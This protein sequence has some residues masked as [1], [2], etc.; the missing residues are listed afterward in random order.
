MTMLQTPP[1][2][3]SP[4]P[5]PARSQ[6]RSFYITGGTLPPDASSYV[7]RDADAELYDSLRNGE[8]CY[9]L[10]TRQM[11]KSSL[12]IRTAARLRAAGLMVAALDLTAIGQNVSPDQWYD[13]LLIS[14]AE[15]VNLED[16]MEEFW[17]ENQRL[18][19]MQ[20]FLAALRQI[21]LPRQKNGIVLFVDEIDAV[22]SLPFSV[23]E[24][25]GGIRECYN[26]RAQDESFEKLT[27]CLLGVATPADLIDD[28]RISPFN[29]GRR[30]PLTDFTPR[31]AAPLAQGMGPKGPALLARVLYWTNGH[32][33]MTQRLC[34]SVSEQAATGNGVTEADVDR[35]CNDLFLSKAARDTDDNLSFVRTRLL[36]SDAD[37]ASLLDL[38]EKVRTGK[39]VP[40]DETNPLC[41]VLRLSGVARI[42]ERGLLQVRNR[43]YDRV[44]DKEWVIAHMPDAEIRRQ[45]AAYWRGMARA[46]GVGTLITTTMAGLAV[47]AFLQA[48]EARVARDEAGKNLQVANAEKNRAQEQQTRAQEQ[49]A[50]AQEQKLLAQKQTAL[51][52]KA[53]ED[54][55]KQKGRAEGETVRANE[56]NKNL[57]A[58]LAQVKTERE[59]ADSARDEARNQRDAALKARRIATEQ[60]EEAVKQR[61]VAVTR[62]EESRRSQIRLAV[63]N[64][65]RLAS[66][67]D[68]SG[69]TLYLSEARR[70]EA[71]DPARDRLHSIRLSEMMQRNPRLA[72]LWSLRGNDLP[73]LQPA[74]FTLSGGVLQGRNASVPFGTGAKI[75]GAVGPFSV[76][77]PETRRAAPVVSALSSSLPARIIWTS[78][79]GRYGLSERE[80]TRK[81]GVVVQQLWSIAEAGQASYRPHF[82]RM[83]DSAAGKLQRSLSFQRRKAHCA[84]GQQPHDS[85]D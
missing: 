43:I 83:G 35:L 21:V 49:Q 53:Q 47:Y 57:Q 41:S 69:A 37:I 11:G 38:Y 75:G 19:A 15:Q 30:I 82:G 9:V 6:E 77:E 55:V 73:A 58:S 24:F 18:G 62:S 23:N 81:K 44:F 85:R 34:R 12:M 33:Y 26:R 80:S 14:L 72:H 64:G 65:L 51:A 67:G 2:A 17:E 76:W 74:G 32:P 4:A 10:N 71:H 63:D 13:G 50:K 8:Y 59:R 61:K 40:D 68:Y 7:P 20:R 70:L 78:P 36:R 27:F 66:Y 46:A 45:K 60:S 56:A 84:S 79:G 39:R 52:I 28:T 25:F 3:A 5:R 54:A 31:E 16:E 29:V 1:D 42:D 48:N 22:R